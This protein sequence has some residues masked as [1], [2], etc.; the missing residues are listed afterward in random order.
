MRHNVSVS[1]SYSEVKCERVCQGC[2]RCEVLKESTLSTVGSR[3]VTV[4]FATIHFH[5]TCRLGPSNPDLW[6]IIVAIQASF[7]YLVRFQVFSGVRVFIPF[8]LV[9]FF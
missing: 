1:S 6:C 2:K 9:Q 4:R 8:C 3:F 5:D 7:L